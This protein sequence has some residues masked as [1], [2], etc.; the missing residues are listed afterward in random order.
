MGADYRTRHTAL[1][2]SLRMVAM[3]DFGWV[4]GALKPRCSPVDVTFDGG[5]ALGASVHRAA[6]TR[7]G[8]VAIRS[9]SIS[10]AYY[11]KCGGNA[12]YAW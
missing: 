4:G 6:D 1:V 9:R 10:I 12:H 8:R 5:H 11:R 7:D 3:A 2:V